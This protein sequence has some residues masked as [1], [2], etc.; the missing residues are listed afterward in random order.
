MTGAGAGAGAG[1]GD[2]D[3]AGAGDGAGEATALTAGDGA[4]GVLGEEADLSGESWSREGD[5]A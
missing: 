2:G 1:D 3:G 5:S 4:V